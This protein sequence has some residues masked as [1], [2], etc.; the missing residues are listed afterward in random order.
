[1]TI[2]SPI[3][4]RAGDFSNPSENSAISI[5][6]NR[7]YWDH[8]PAQEYPDSNVVK[9]SV[10][11]TAPDLPSGSTIRYFAAGNIANGNFQNTGDR[12]VGT[13]GSGI[14][15][16]ASN[17]DAKAD[18]LITFPNPGNDV[19]S[20]KDQ[21]GNGKNG[22]VSFFTTSGQIMATADLKDGRVEVPQISPG[23]YLLKI[24]QGS[25]TMIVR[26]IKQ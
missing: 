26:W 20:I 25:E 5:S 13:N 19:I 7:Q 8:D 24:L 6:E 4:T 17:E 2:L 16:V 1:M 12:I 15:V 3:N 9:W 11:W 23:L 10:D 18:N 22:T 14:V 21:N